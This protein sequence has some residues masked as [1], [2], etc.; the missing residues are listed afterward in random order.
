MVGSNRLVGGKEGLFKP[1]MWE[2]II[3]DLIKKNST[4]LLRL[5]D[6]DVFTVYKISS[7]LKFTL[8]V[9]S[10]DGERREEREAA[11]RL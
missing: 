4:Q 2:Q 8:K 5:I 11:R 3:S 10:G 1:Q 6:V 9:C 7:L